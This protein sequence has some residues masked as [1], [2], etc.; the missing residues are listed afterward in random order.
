MKKVILSFS[1]LVSIVFIYAQVMATSNA[2]IGKPQAAAFSWSNT[3]IDFGKIQQGVPKTATFEF[4]NSGDVPLVITNAK[5]SCGC[6][7]ADF[8][9]DTP[10]MPGQSAKITAT[11]NAANPGQFTKTVTVTANTAEKTHVLT[12]TGE[13]VTQ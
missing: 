8:P 10:I 3:K 1:V 2:D 12:I 6:T 11:Y 9:K 13:V 5:G 4:T 7:V